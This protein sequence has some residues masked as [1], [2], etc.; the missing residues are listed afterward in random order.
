MTNAQ[1]ISAI[2]DVVENYKYMVANCSKVGPIFYA[3]IKDGLVQKSNSSEAFMNASWG[4]IELW[5]NDKSTGL[6]RGPHR[7]FVSEDGGID[8]QYSIVG[9]WR[10]STY[11]DSWTPNIQILKLGTNISIKLTQGSLKEQMSQVMKIL[12][13]VDDCSTQDSVDMVL[14]L[15]KESKI[16]D[17]EGIID[18]LVKENKLLK[19]KIEKIRSLIDA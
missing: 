8:E 10:I 2:N 4:I 13:L 12:P 14:S 6:C 17:K 11:G 16:N 7:F 9:K 5:L 15:I 18:A 1:L 19:E 3:H